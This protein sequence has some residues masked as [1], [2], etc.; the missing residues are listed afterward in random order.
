MLQPVYFAGIGGPSKA[1]YGFDLDETPWDRTLHIVVIQSQPGNSLWNSEGGRNDI[2]NLA[3]RQNVAKVPIHQLRYHV[4]LDLESAVHG[5]EM[6]V[7]IDTSKLKRRDGFE[8][9]GLFRKTYQILSDLLVPELARCYVDFD[10]R[11]QLSDDE[12][13]RF[14]AILGYYSPHRL[15]RLPASTFIGR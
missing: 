13:E 10:E 9:T 5:I 2:L 4:I 1:Q 12:I 7:H 3:L 8:S 14:F 15:A 6:P 11:R